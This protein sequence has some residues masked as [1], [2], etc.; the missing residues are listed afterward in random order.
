[1]SIASAGNN[2]VLDFGKALAAGA[3]TFTFPAKLLS[4]ESALVPVINHETVVP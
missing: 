3:N 1:M 4:A 2:A